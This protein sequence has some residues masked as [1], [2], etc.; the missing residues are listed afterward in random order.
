[1]AYAA[2]DWGSPFIQSMV[3]ATKWSA[4]ASTPDIAM[5]TFARAHVEIAL[6][7]AIGFASV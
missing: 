2:T 1:M 7:N 6:A 4:I 3:L 5:K